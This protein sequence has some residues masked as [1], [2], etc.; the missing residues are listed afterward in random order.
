[1]NGEEHSEVE[2]SSLGLQL[3]ITQTVKMDEIGKREEIRL[4]VCLRVFVYMYIYMIGEYTGVWKF[5][6]TDFK[7]PQKCPLTKS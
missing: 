4:G 2:F 3:S 6:P 5:V 7:Y 1:M